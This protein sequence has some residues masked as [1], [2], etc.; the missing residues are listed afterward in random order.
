MKTKYLSYSQI[1]T[2]LNC[3]HKYELMYVEKIQCNSDSIEAYM[4]KIVHEVLDWI[5]SN[6]KDYYIWDKIESKYN[7]FWSDNWHSQIY[8]A[9]IRKQYDKNYFLKL[10]LEC[11]RNY[12]RNNNG[13]NI[14]SENLIG[15]EISVNTKIG[16]YSFKAIIDRLDDNQEYLE[17]HDYKTGKPYTRSK[18]KK[19]IQLAIYL[20]AV[21]QKYPDRKIAANWHFLKEKNKNSQHVRI[22]LDD[23]ELESKKQ[24]IL[25]YS[26]ALNLAIKNN[27]FH[28]NESFLCN[29]CYLW[30]YCEAKKIYH[31]KNPSI[32]AK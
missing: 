20:L 31:E 3:S 30:D 24:E 17:V 29:W 7:Q 5:Y 9:P 16:Q 21:K 2:F 28:A 22:I 13:P 4:G 14:S 12:Y 6:K 15:S 11:L 1:N 25:K 19:D 26:N 18:I 10:G 8:I 32:N 27:D 23:D